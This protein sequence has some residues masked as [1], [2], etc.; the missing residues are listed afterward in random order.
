MQN[1]DM[2]QTPERK[3]LFNKRFI[4]YFWLIIVSF[5]VGATPF[6]W[7]SIFGNLAAWELGAI[8]FIYL[9]ILIFIIDIIIILIYELIVASK[10]NKNNEINFKLQ[11]RISLVYS[12]IY[13]IYISI[14]VYIF[15]LLSKFTDENKQAINTQEELMIN[16]G[17]LTVMLLLNIAHYILAKNE[18]NIS[19]KLAVF[20][21]IIIVLV[22]IFNIFIYTP[23]QIKKYQHIK[24]QNIFEIAIKNKDLNT[25]LTVN[26]DIIC[27]REL[28]IRHN[29]PQLC[30]QIPDSVSGDPRETERY[31]CLYAIAMNTKNEA[32]C[33]LIAENVKDKWNMNTSHCL[34]GVSD[35]KKQ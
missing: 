31:T 19:R 23:K 4:F 3:H 33:A 12:T 27:N 28:G 16:I 10:K 32:I 20:T 17:I 7:V 25:C 8:V 24:K 34:K 6:A 2:L 35:A 1:F 11:K 21:T 26:S 5:I 30:L 13:I 9:W 18:K 22:S 15:L 29:D 14:L